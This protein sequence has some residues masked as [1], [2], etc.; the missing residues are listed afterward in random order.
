MFVKNKRN[1][2]VKWFDDFTNN[3]NKTF[4]CLH[5]LGTIN[6]IISLYGL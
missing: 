1:S 2:I 4:L 3:K 5:R 6:Q